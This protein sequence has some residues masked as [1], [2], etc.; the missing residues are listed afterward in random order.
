[1]NK[2]DEFSNIM[3]QR[4][5]ELYNTIKFSELEIIELQDQLNNVCNSKEYFISELEG[6]EDDEKYKKWKNN[7]FITLQNNFIILQNKYDQLKVDY[8]NLLKSKQ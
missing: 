8:N 2:R 6:I 5:K 3:K 7:K 4:I 1:M